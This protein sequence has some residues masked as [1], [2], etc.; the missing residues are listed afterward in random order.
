AHF[1]GTAWQSTHPDKAR[2][3]AELP[4]STCELVLQIDGSIVKSSPAWQWQ[5]NCFENDAWQMCIDENL[6]RSENGPRISQ[7]LFKGRRAA[8]TLIGVIYHYGITLIS[9]AALL[10][11]FLKVRGR[12]R[13]HVLAFL[14]AAACIGG[15]F[16]RAFI[17]AWVD[18]LS[19]PSVVFQY[20]H[21]S[22]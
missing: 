21:A 18:V 13:S 11:S 1:A 17:L 19:F 20:T 16:V 22:Y 3:D 14:F 15:V 10:V 7:R 6:Q 4:C 8:L 12:L 9:V 2:F 5:P